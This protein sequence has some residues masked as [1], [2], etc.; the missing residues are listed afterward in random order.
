MNTTQFTWCKSAM[1]NHPQPVPPIYQPEVAAA[2]IVDV[3]FDG[4]AYG[5]RGAFDDR[6]GGVLDPSFLTSLPDAA[7]SLVEAVAASTRF[8][9]GAGPR[10]AATRARVASGGESERVGEGQGGQEMSA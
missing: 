8:R 2:R 6:A 9:L 5:A 3:V 1:P 7:W 10:R 4:R